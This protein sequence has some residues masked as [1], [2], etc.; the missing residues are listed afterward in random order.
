VVRLQSNTE[1]QDVGPRTDISKLCKLFPA[2]QRSNVPSEGD[3]T[4]ICNSTNIT[5]T[6]LLEPNKFVKSYTVAGISDIYAM[7]FRYVKLEYFPLYQYNYIL[8]KNMPIIPG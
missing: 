2:Y 1:L 6:G 3:A 4:S 7:Y 8:I 5:L